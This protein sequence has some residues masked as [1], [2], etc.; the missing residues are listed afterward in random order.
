LKEIKEM[1]LTI[2]SSSYSDDITRLNIRSETLRG[3]IS[4]IGNA[5]INEA[6]S[7]SNQN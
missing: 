2:N 6:H 3:M 1:I 5:A 7:L 4:D